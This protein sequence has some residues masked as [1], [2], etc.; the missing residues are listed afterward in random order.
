MT[1]STSHRYSIGV[2]IGGTK[3]LGGIVDRDGSIIHSSRKDTPRE[4]GHAL[5]TTIA[6]VIDELLIYAKSKSIEIPAIGI[7]T[8]GVISPD[9]RTVSYAPNIAGWWEPFEIGRA[10]V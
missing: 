5:V 3:V 2:D 8:A 6:D 9:R 1:Q 4:G 10:H 7:C